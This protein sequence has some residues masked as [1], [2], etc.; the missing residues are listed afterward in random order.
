M[1]SELTATFDFSAWR[2]RD[3]IAFMKLQ[4]GSGDPGEKIDA[5][6]KM[7]STAIV[8]WDLA[9]DPHDIESFA[10]LTMQEWAAV[11]NQ[12]GEAISKSFQPQAE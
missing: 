11:L 12:F 5:L 10:D 4:S 8:E 6:M 7:V 1:S 9:S 2:M 3:Y